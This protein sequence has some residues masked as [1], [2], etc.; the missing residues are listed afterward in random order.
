MYMPRCAVT[1]MAVCG[2]GVWVRV[3]YQG[4]VYRVGIQGGDTGVYYPA[5]LHRARKTH[6]SGAGPGSS[7]RELEWVV[8]S[9]A[10]RPSAPHPFGAR[11]AMLASLG[12]PRANA[13][14][15]PIGRELTSFYGIL[16]KTA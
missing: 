4:G 10:P 14:S 13:A 6:D 15:G 16:V 9:A 8:M 5:T 3:W 12:A 7:C 1:A 2:Y 11:S